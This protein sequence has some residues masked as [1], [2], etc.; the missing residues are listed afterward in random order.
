MEDHRFGHIVIDGTEY[1][2]DVIVLPSRV[3]PNWWR[4]DGHSLV[5]ED[6]SDVID[7]LPDHVVVGTGAYGRMK[8]DR[9]C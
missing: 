3:V 9:E 1:T 8:P 6:L 4:K 2:K 5:L 7:D